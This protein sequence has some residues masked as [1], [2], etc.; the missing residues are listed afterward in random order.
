MLRR[1]EEAFG[2]S[3][4]LNSRGLKHQHYARRV[5]RTARRTPQPR[6]TAFGG[7]PHRLAGEDTRQTGRGTRVR[8]TFEITNE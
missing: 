4:G 7:P 1:N 2:G 5:G 8:R 6:A 3:S